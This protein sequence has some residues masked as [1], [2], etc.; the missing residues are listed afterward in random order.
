MPAFAEEIREAEQEGVKIILLAAPTKVLAD[1]RGHVVGI[2]CTRMRLGDFDNKGRRI[3]VPIE[4]STFTLQVDRIISAIGEFADVHELRNS[5][6]NWDTN[7][8]GTIA[9]DEEGRTSIPGVFAGGD[10]AIG[11]ATVIKAIAAGE[12]AAVAIDR[13]LAGTAHREYPWRQR[14][15]SPVPH[16]TSAEPIVAPMLRTELVPVP[17]RCRSFDEVQVAID[18]EV[19][20]KEAQRCLR[21]DYGEEGGEFTEM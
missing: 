3:P 16:D 7:R 14:R 2:E 5:H 12:R 4:N 1:A 15:R 19:A 6:M 8:D 13:Y 18:P 17:V 20:R 10:V 11:A 21:C 9:I